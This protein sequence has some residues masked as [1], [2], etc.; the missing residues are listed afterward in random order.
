MVKV[1]YS[2]EFGRRTVPPRGRTRQDEVEALKRAA[3]VRR[4]IARGVDG[5]NAAHVPPDLRRDRIDEAQR[6]RDAWGPPSRAVALFLNAEVAALPDT[7]S[8]IAR[9]DPYCY[10][11]G[12]VFERQ[13]AAALGLYVEAP[14]PTLV[15]HWLGSLP[16]FGKQKRNLARRAGFATLHAEVQPYLKA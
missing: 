7:E 11:C 4:V 16:A 12:F 5:F 2:E 14:A 15:M 10:A 9:A 6:F 8:E 1:I 3:V 13:R